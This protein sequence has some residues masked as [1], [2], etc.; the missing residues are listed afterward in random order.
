MFTKKIPLFKAFGI[1]IGI[2]ASWFII[3]VLVTWSLAAGLF[4]Q[5]YEELGTTSYW[6]MGLV[7]AV[8]LFV[9]IILHE[10]GHAVTAQHYGLKIRGITL[11]IF[12]GVAEMQDEPP[13]A[14]SEFFVA[15]A[16]PVVSVLLAILASIGLPS[17]R[18]RAASARP[19]ISPP[20]SAAASA[21]F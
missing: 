9:S 12:G 20:G 14:A 15:I 19:R 18:Q 3:L 16:G 6:V 10:L 4:P 7:G 11:F 8:G 17:G 2:D 13:T 1:P 5:K 21:C